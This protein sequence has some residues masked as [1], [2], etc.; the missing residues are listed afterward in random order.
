M[1]LRNAVNSPFS[2]CSLNAL[3]LLPKILHIHSSRFL[4]GRLYCPEGLEKFGRGE[5]GKGVRQTLRT[6]G[7]AKV[8]KV[9]S[10]HLHIICALN[11]FSSSTV[12]G[13]NPN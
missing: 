11:F 9:L 4:S 13:T 10:Y 2:P 8:C 3:C 12:L 1:I 7:N 5:G 6:T